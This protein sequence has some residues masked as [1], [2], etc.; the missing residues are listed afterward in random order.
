MR[1]AQITILKYKN[2]LFV[3]FMLFHWWNN[4][5]QD[6]GFLV[7]G[8]VM[9]ARS[10]APIENVNITVTGSQEGTTTNKLGQFS[11]WIKT[12]PFELVF[13]HVAYENAS[14]YY[15]HSPLQALRINLEERTEPLTGV[16][17]TSQNIDTIYA[18][19]VY[20]VLDYE[21]C[22]EGIMLLIF[23]SRLARSELRFQ[24]YSGHVL[25]ELK[26]LPTKPLALFK[27]CL[28]EIHLLSHD[29][30]YQITTG[31]SGLV[32]YPPY[33]IDHFHEVMSSCKF[34][35][36][37]KVYFEVMG[38]QELVNQYYYVTTTDTTSHLLA[39]SIDHEK[40]GFL[41]Q[42]PENYLPEYPATGPDPIESFNGTAGD[43]RLLRMIRNKE[44]ELR[45]NKLAYLSPIFAP[46]FALQ[47]SVVI[48]DHPNN[49]IRIYDQYD[50]LIGTT[51]IE[52]HLSRKNDSVSG[53]VYG[54]AKPTKWLKEIYL[55]EIK[56]KAYT[57]FQNLNGTRDLKEIDLHT[58]KTS[59]ILNIPFPYVQKIK[60]RDGM[61]Y[62]VYK[63]F[64]ESQRK[65][66]FRQRIN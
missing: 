51:P 8:S 6:S 50:S 31:K 40:L 41:R 1:G 32:L 54:L 45:F 48:F 49:L 4:Y 13:S 66:L 22:E 9:D 60:I 11:I 58:G 10:G 15:D 17:I 38:F 57:T 19:R 14:L 56:N 18:D 28:G 64:G 24:D 20:S 27:D 61:L 44:A 34:M 7:S 39:V 59:Y 46:S 36:G 62:Y 33:S 23:K 63:G 2:L 35:I 29:K 42:N 43:L 37:E 65:K 30:A 52:Y 5:G 47:D 12:L 16:T 26:V 25:H 3:V 53:L 21:L 55:D